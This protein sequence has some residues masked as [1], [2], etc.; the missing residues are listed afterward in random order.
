MHGSV[1]EHVCVSVKFARLSAH[2]WSSRLVDPALS[3]LVML[4]ALLEARSGVRSS[5]RRVIPIRRLSDF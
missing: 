3:D 5:K 2:F 1:G 4:A